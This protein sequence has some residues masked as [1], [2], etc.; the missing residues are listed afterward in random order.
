MIAVP[1][2]AG[3]I[4]E[5]LKQIELANTEA[6]VIELRLDF[7][8]ELSEKELE[9]LIKKCSKPVICTC[10]R[11]EE[12]GMFRESEGKRLAVLKNAVKLKADF[13]DIEFETKAEAK[14]KF[15]EYA[16]NHKQS[17][18]ILSRHFF[19]L[20][21]SLEELSKLLNKMAKEKPYAIK[22]VS[23]ANTLE[24]NKIIFSLLKEAKKKGLRLIAFCMGQL[25]KDSRI[26]SMPL[27]G[28]LTFAS[29]GKGDESADGQI[30]ITEM[31]K[32]YAGLRV[33]F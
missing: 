20:T 9:R 31:K 17:K 22:I 2:V 27:G 7:F 26:L 14:K 32:I 29:L 10:R 25:G 33:M 16:K 24:D 18:I 30:P 13:I 28:F 15:Y 4:E 23:R 21:P 11:V 12:G 8:A 3:N 5:A 6:D 19:G 1:I